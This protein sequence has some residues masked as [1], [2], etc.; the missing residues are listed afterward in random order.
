MD[1][2]KDEN[3]CY[4]LFMLALKDIGRVNKFKIMTD[5]WY[6]LYKHGEMSFEKLGYHVIYG[7]MPRDSR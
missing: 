5:P 2:P 6:E 7:T 1:V 3:C 4:H